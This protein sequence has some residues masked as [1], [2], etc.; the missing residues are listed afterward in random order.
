MI[1]EKTLEWWLQSIDSEWLNTNARDTLQGFMEEKK[2]IEH[3]VPF[4]LIAPL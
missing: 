4:P 2:A 1:R 3:H